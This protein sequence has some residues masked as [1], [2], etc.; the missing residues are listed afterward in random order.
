LFYKRKTTLGAGQIVSET[1]DL[2][3]DTGALTPEGF[4]RIEEIQRL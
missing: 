1:G 4:V 2:K 3:L